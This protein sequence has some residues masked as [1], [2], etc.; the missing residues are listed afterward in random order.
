MELT[1]LARV[2]QGVSPAG[3]AAVV[4]GFPGVRAYVFERLREA[5]INVHETENIIFADAEAA[6]ARLSLEGNPSADVVAAIKNGNPHVLDV[7]VVAINAP[8]S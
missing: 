7:H 2:V 6:V 3:D 5:G 8:E 4:Q 1:T